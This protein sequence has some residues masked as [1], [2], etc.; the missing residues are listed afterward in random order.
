MRSNYTLR[1]ATS[2]DADAVSE[3][4][5]ASYPILMRSAYEESVLAPALGLMTRANPVLLSSGSYYVAEAVGGELVGSGGWTP[6]RPGTASVEPGL[7]HLRHF[8][9]HPEWTRRGIAGAI[10]ATCDRTARAAGITTFECYAS[11][12]AEQFYAALGFVRVRAMDMEL[13]GN[14]V[15]PGILMRRK[16]DR[17]CRSGGPSFD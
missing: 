9:V 7:G 17:G 3:L 15:L 11:L 16:L 1:L 12:N 13:G 8:A 14:V 5:R 6:E 2:Q 10:Y 4:L